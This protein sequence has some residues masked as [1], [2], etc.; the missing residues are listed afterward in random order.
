MYWIH[1]S[2]VHS[3]CVDREGRRVDHDTD[4]IKNHKFNRWTFSSN[5]IKYRDN[6]ITER[7]KQKQI[8][9]IPRIFDMSIQ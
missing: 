8:A 9:N 4:L 2:T 3:T 1:R 6:F 7:T 5:L